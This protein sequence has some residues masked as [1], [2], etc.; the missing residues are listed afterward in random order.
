[1][2]IQLLRPQ[3]VATFEKSKKFISPIVPMI[4]NHVLPIIA[5]TVVFYG[6]LSLKDRNTQHVE[7]QGM[8]LNAAT[9]QSAAA[10]AAVAA[11]GLRDINVSPMVIGHDTFKNSDNHILFIGFDWACEE[12]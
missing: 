7:R 4:Q 8:A 6:F 3:V 2:L 9:S 1:M 5:L 10:Q 11:K 12:D